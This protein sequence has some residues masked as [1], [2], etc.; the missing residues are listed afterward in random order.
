MCD[1][2]MYRL[3]VGVKHPLPKEKGSD[4]V[5]PENLPQWNGLIKIV[6]SNWQ[7]LSIVRQFKFK[8]PDVSRVKCEVCVGVGVGCV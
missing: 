6:L 5:L 1:L 2:G 3:S 7:F 8:W 4:A